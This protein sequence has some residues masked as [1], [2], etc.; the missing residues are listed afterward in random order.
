MHPQDNASALEYRIPLDDARAL[1][2]GSDRDLKHAVLQGNQKAPWHVRHNDLWIWNELTSDWDRKTYDDILTVTR[3]THTILARIFLV[4]GLRHLAV[5]I[6][7]LSTAAEPITGFKCPAKHMSGQSEVSS[8]ASGSGS[9]SSHKIGAGTA[10]CSA[11]SD[12]SARSDEL[13]ST[14]T[15]TYSRVR[16]SKYGLS[17]QS[18]RST[19]EWTTSSEEDFPSG[20]ELIAEVR[21]KGKRRAR[22]R[23][24]T[25]EIVDSTPCD[26]KPKRVRRGSAGGAIKEEGIELG[27]HEVINVDE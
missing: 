19:E 20:D 8:T 7:A 27:P 2:L 21:D 25:V 5:E 9:V 23:S 6:A 26:Q 4:E 14:S 12:P 22:D 18:A 13:G 10:A 1:T 16:R 15:S 17:T 11:V 24:P 3:G